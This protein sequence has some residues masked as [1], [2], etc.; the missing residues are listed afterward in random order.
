VRARLEAVRAMM[1]ENDGHVDVE[2][3]RLLH[4]ALPF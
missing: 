3:R 2:S 4:D 1:P